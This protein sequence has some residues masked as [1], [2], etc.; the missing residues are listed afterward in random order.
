[1][2][3]AVSSTPRLVDSST[4]RTPHKLNTTHPSCSFLNWIAILLYF[5]S[6]PPKAFVRRDPDT[7]VV[8]P[9]ESVLVAEP[10]FWE[11]WKEG[12]GLLAEPGFFQLS[13]AFIFSVP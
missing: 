13:A 3:L 10:S 5:E 6:E 7:L 11:F 4:H 1:M 8:P 12:F 9:E 2:N